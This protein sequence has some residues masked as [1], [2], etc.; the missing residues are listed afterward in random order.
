MDAIRY[1]GAI[2]VICGGIHV[3]GNASMGQEATT[4]AQGSEDTAARALYD[5]MIKAMRTAKT[6]YYESSSHREPVTPGSAVTGVTLKVWLK[7]PNYFRV[8]ALAELDNP[9]KECAGFL[10][11]D[12]ENAWTYWRTARPKFSTEDAGTYEKTRWNVYVKEPA[13]DGLGGS[14]GQYSIGHQSLVPG[15]LAM[16]LVD[17]SIFHGYTSCLEPYIDAVRSI[18][19]ET[20]GN[21]ECD[22]IE[23]SIMKGQR[24]QCLWLAKTDHLPRKLKEILR[25]ANGDLINYEQWTNVRVNADIPDEMF[26]WRPPEGWKQWHRPIFEESVRVLEPGTAAPDFEVHASDGR[27]V[28]L[29]DLRGKVVWLTFWKLGC[30]AC[31]WELPV[32]EKLQREHGDKG[33]VVV[34][35]NPVDEKELALSV[36]A[37]EGITFLNI[38]A[39]SKEARES[40]DQYKCSGYPLN[41]IID[42]D[43]K[44]ADGWYGYDYRVGNVRG[45]KTLRRLGIL[46]AGGPGS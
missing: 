2:A 27:R 3:A 7:K 43:G 13:P 40:A 4:Q 41:Y 18:G 28:R 22:A 42:R 14:S 26:S 46:N 36:L 19:T 6:I 44:V 24:R 20:V 8:E 17:P 45:S 39:A 30:P 5:N 9:E 32:L 37:K 31:R 16:A 23:V 34:G 38:L 35:I 10:V 11:G 21:E 29:S 33:L 12:G 1:L 15:Y 25:V